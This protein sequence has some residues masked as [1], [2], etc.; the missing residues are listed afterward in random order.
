M[1]TLPPPLVDDVDA[2]LTAALT[3]ASGQP[4]YALSD[5]ERAS[6]HAVYAAYEALLGQP[7]PALNSP[8]LAGCNQYL[9][10]G[11]SQ[12][13]VGQRLAALRSSLLAS[14]NACPYCGFGE[15]TDLDHY[16]PKP[17][18]QA[19]AIYPR[20]LVP[21]CAACNNAKRAIVP[22]V[23]PDPGLI[24]AYFQALP[25][26]EFFCAD[27][28]YAAGVLDVTFRIETHV[29]GQPLEEMLQFQLTRMKLNARYPR[30]VNK[31][32]SEQRTGILMMREADGDPARLSAYLGRSARS[33]AGNFGLN[34][35]RP[36]LFRALAQNAAFCEEPELFLGERGYG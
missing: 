25:D 4:V 32:L 21:S 26:L 14:A 7:G 27:V 31:F 6:V 1:W 15:P 18:Y 13:Q 34:D 2:Q 16:L 20:N 35:W 22:G 33:L 5:A 10:D 17:L 12:V 23:G 29:V 11:Y 36:A 30:Q 28:D 9:A 24:H 8:A 19:L 3:F